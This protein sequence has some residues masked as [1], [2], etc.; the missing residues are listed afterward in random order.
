MFLK[1]FKIEAN[2]NL[3]WLPLLEKKTVIQTL[4]NCSRTYLIR[5]KKYVFVDQ[6]FTEFENMA[7][8]YNRIFQNPPFF[9]N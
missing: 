6:V 4:Q 5:S 2:Q 1:K 8:F 7:F 9:N 3:K